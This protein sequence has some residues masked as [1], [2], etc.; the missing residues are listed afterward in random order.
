MP[1]QIKGNKVNGEAQTR[2]IVPKRSL[3]DWR[4]PSRPFKRRDREFY[5]TIVAIAA[6]VG[7]V[8]F[9]VE[10]IMPVLLIISVVFLFYVMNTVEPEKIEYRITNKG[11]EVSGRLTEWE[12]LT[13]FWFTK[14]HNDELLVF[15]MTTFPSR[16]EVVVNIP[17]KEKLR[18]VIKEYLEEEEAP[19][20]FLDKSSNWFAKRLPNN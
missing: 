9:I 3:F 10:G 2:K 11:I 8:I 1:A 7:L 14:R 19:P 12:R 17:D 18:K 15:E 4:A 5:V 16:L 20:S 13:R 6:I